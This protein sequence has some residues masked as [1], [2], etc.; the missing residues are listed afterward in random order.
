MFSIM[1]M[2]L[3]TPNCLAVRHARM[4]ASALPVRATN[5]CADLMF[6]SIRLATERPSALMIITWLVSTRSISSSQR[7][8]SFSKIL[9]FMSC[10]SMLTTLTAVLPPPTIKTFFTSGELSFPMIILML[11]TYSLVV[12]K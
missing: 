4:L 5:A 1:A 3:R 7:R 12:M 9:A 2:V 11:G 10:G 6:S 8:G